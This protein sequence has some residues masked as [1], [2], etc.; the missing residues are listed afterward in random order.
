MGHGDAATRDLVLVARPNASMGRSDAPVAERGL[1]QAIEREVE[2]SRRGQKTEFPVVL[3]LISD[4][5]EV[6]PD[7]IVTQ[8]IVPLSAG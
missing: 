3:K 2:K 8:M 7:A 6:A 5:R 4:P 1:T